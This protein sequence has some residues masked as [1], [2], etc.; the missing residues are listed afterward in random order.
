MSLFKKE[1]EN[2]GMVYIA[3][4]VSENTIKNVDVITN[5]GVNFVR[6]DSGLHSFECMN[7]NQRQYIGDNIWDAIKN[8]ERIQSYLMNQG[9][10]GE[11]DHPTQETSDA[12]LT[13][14]RIQAI[15]MPN[16]SHKIINPRVEANMLNATIETSSGTEA[17]RGMCNEIIQGLIPTFSCRA[18]ANLI[19]KNGK[20][21]VIVKKLITYDWVLFPSHKEAVATTSPIIISKGMKTVMESVQDTT[22]AAGQYSK[23]IMINLKDILS[24]IGCKDINTQLIMESFDLS[25]ESITDF[26]PNA[27]HAIIKD[28]DNVIYCKVDPKTTREVKDFLASR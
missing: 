12:P 4:Q 26:T 27:T 5:K 15:W 18:I 14:E 23:D 22:K 16:R 6:F 8:S 13:P 17:G 19:T 11:M 28:R 10:F 1:N 24:N 9:W 25:K 20:P 7:R 2:L 21:T 3:E